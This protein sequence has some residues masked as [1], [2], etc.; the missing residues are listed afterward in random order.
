MNKLK[1]LPRVAVAFVLAFLA[2]GC[3]DDLVVENPNQPTP[4]VLNTE[5]GLKRQATGIYGTITSDYYWMGLTLLEGM[6]DAIPSRVGNFGL[7]DAHNPEEIIYSD[8]QKH[9]PIDTRSGETN[10]QF[11]T[12]VNNR[13]IAEP[14]V[15]YLWRQMYRINNEANLILQTLEGGQVKFLSDA[16]N[17]AKAY[18]AWAYFWK[19]F[20]YSNIGALY[21]R[22]VI[23][24]KYGE[25]N[26]NYKT[27]AEMVAESNRM[28]DLAIENAPG[29]DAVANVVVPDL[30]KIGTIAKPTS[31]SLAEAANTF[32]ARNLLFVKY[33]SDMTP[34]D[35]Q[36]IEALTAKGLT[37]NTNTFVLRFDQATYAGTGQILNRTGAV[38]GGGVWSYVSERLI[39]EFDPAD[40]RLKSAFFQTMSAGKPTYV[41]TGDRGWNHITTWRGKEP[42]FEQTAVGSAPLYLVSAEENQLMAAEAKLALGKTAEAA[43]LVDGVRTMQNAGLP[44]LNPATFSFEDIRRERRTALVARGV[45]FYD[46]RRL[47]V[48][49]PKAQGG[50]RQNAWVWQKTADGKTITK[51]DTKAE[52]IYNFLPYWPVP[53]HE[54]TFNPPAD[55]GVGGAK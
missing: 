35:W 2:V 3:A 28:F 18:K 34:A 31:K 11:L 8:G 44:K 30:F 54:L 53:A 55:G 25:T 49:L 15:L 46:Y 9:R 41:Y 4:A 10:G 26:G 43:A 29:F 42:V 45:S 36:Q 19:G 13:T 14:T 20:A 6:G 40:N 39:Q 37:S 12:R 50:G 7:V 52:I 16:E 33:K 1:L 47:K 51:L 22:G 27:P 17:K 24:D 32:K 48:I 5:E 38:G 21:E 23:I